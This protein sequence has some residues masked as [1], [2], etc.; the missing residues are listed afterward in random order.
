MMLKWIISINK[1]DL[2]NGE[3][4]MQPKS[5]LSLIIVDEDMNPKYVTFYTGISPSRVWNKGDL[6]PKTQLLEKDN[7]WELKSPLPVESPLVDHVNGLLSIIEP[8][9]R[10]FREITESHY[11]LLS[12]AV[13]FGEERPEIYFDK[14][15]LKKLSDLNLGLDIDLYCLD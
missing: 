14:N 10:K 2:N 12:C 4:Y 13:Y 5:H 6:R 11:S 9:K 8:A 7:G 1:I 3:T 15:L